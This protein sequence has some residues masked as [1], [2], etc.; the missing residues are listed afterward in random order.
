MIPAFDSLWSF[1]CHARFT[2]PL[3]WHQWKA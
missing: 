3:S 2:V 1:S